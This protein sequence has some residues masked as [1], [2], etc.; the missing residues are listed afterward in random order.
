[1]MNFKPEDLNFHRE[2][3]QDHLASLRPK[4]FP[5]LYKKEVAG[6][7]N[8]SHRRGNPYVRDGKALVSCVMTADDVKGEVRA[9]V[10]KIGGFDKAFNRQDRILV[11]PNFNSDDPPPGS[12]SLDFIEAVIHVLRDHGYM[13]I[14]V[15]EGAGRPWVPTEQVFTNTG[16]AA[17]MAEIDAPLM[18]LDKSEYADVDING[19]YLDEIAY[20][21]NLEAFDKIIYLP[22]MKTHFLAGFSMSLKFVVGLTHLKDRFILHA[23]NN[24]FVSERSVEM[25]IPVQPDL[26]IMDGRMS[27]ISGG[28]AQ[29]L[30]V[31]PGM[32]LASGDSVALD[33]QGVRFLQNYAGVNHLV[34]NAWDLPQIRTAVKNG[35]GIQSDTELSLVR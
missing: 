16:L 13:N 8:L 14:T 31:H 32:I 30:V 33:V 17:K 19:E 18:D 23:D 12:S 35:I 6:R 1:M 10:E 28:P 4:D 11:K 15:G 2:E 21:K 5:L 3:Y 20:A 9:A 24:M 25:G 27:F 26:I 22:T 7:M 29:G 34:G